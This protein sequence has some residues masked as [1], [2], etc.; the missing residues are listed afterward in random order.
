MRKLGFV[1]GDSKSNFIFATHDKY[2]AVEIQKYL[3]D[4]KKAR[5]HIIDGLIKA[6]SIIFVVLTHSI[7]RWIPE[8]SN[9]Q[10]YNFI[11][12]AQMPLFMYV[13]GRLFEKR[14]SYT[15]FT[16]FFKFALK[17]FSYL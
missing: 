6:I 3:R 2:K 14:K 4:K 13:A 8:L 16:D 15:T 12:Y 17:S 10:F 7:A 5:L 11:F 9:S 1:F